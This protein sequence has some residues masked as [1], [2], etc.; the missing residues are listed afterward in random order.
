M[1][2]YIKIACHMPVNIYST[3]LKLLYHKKETSRKKKKER[4]KKKR[5]GRGR[6]EESF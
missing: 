2:L 5:K 6:E 3:T 4:K 1:N